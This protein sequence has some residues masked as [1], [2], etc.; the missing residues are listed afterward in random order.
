MPFW[1]EAA[2]CVRQNN[3]SFRRLF[4][5]CMIMLSHITG[6]QT[7]ICPAGLFLFDITAKKAQPQWTEKVRLLPRL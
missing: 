2:G 4:L 5:P 6:L 1:L 3:Q 7:V